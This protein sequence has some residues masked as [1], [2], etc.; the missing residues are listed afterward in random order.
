MQCIKELIRK[1]SDWIP[2]EKGYSVYIRPCFIG[3]GE[4]LGVGPPISAL[5]YC[6]LSPV[7]PYYRTGFAAVSL[8]AEE[9]FVR[10]WPG[11]TGSYKIGA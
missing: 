11:G 1:D 4:F 2:S 9:K 6:I 10:A 8:Y 3:T 5:L 7:G